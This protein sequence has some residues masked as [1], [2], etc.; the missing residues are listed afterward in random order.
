MKKILKIMLI[1]FSS[2]I[3]IL[4]I[5]LLIIRFNSPGKLAPLTDTN[6][7]IIPGSI[8][9]KIWV[10]VN[11]IK[12]GMF[13]RSENPENPVILFLH[14]GPGTP[15]LQFIS[16]LEKTER[17]EKYF[18]VCYWDQRGAG[19]TYQK[20]TDSESMTI[21]QMVDDAHKVTEYLKSR[22]GQ[23]KICLIGQS[24][25]TYLGVKVIEK[26]PE[27]YKAYIGIG[28][29]AYQ[30]QS[31]QLAYNYM[32]QHAKE[33]GDNK[34][35]ENLK[36]HDPYSVGFPQKDYNYKVRTPLMNKYGIGMLHEG[37]TIGK[38]LGALIGFKGYTIK[39]KINFF[40][41]ADF[42]IEL[43]FG[44]LTNDNL[45][46]SAPKFDVPFYVAHGIYDYM[47]SYTL[48]K[49]YIDFIDA[50]KKRFYTFDNSAH[51]PNMEEP[52][53]FVRIVREITSENTY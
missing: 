45:F 9:E 2:L 52:E 28:Q 50:P 7:D 27:D 3:G 5:C 42:S 35:V 14:G 4:I 41:G 24:W 37:V 51:S 49:K 29:L 11:G 21:E 39:E 34:M 46:E 8:S 22:F 16:K 20:S 36:K 6:G 26:Y 19:M 18:T 44:T 33:I 31:E 13:I 32:L 48:A 15:L 30:L 40:R 53:K 17:L 23:D 10:E 43:L 38:I 25:G 47:V 1:A 12:Q